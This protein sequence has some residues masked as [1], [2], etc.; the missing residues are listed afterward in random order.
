MILFI[1][2]ENEYSGD[3]I[4][5]NEKDIARCKPVSRIP[6]YEFCL[7]GEQPYQHMVSESKFRFEPVAFEFGK[8]YIG[9]YIFGLELHYTNIT[10]NLSIDGEFDI[11][12]LFC[13]PPQA[14]CILGV[15]RIGLYFAQC[16][17]GVEFM[18]DVSQVKLR[19]ITVFAIDTADVL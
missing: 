8:L 19:D 13:Q 15:H 4:L 14:L 6:L 7:A 1:F 11:C 5:W 2:R 16:G 9:R 3:L 10:K 18:F 12:H 17:R